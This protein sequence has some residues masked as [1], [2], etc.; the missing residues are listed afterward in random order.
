MDTANWF[1]G[2]MIL[3]K[4]SE[5]NRYKTD[6]LPLA[7][8]K[9]A[10]SSNQN[11][12][13]GESDGFG[14]SF[15]I[16]EN[17]DPIFAARYFADPFW[18]NGFF[19]VNAIVQPLLSP[20]LFGSDAPDMISKLKVLIVEDDFMIA[21]MSEDLLVNGGFDV[22]GIAATVEEAVCLGLRHKPDLALIDFRLADGGFGTE[23]ATRLRAVER[24]GV[25]YATGNSTH[26][27]MQ[28]AEGEAC[29]AKPYRAQ[30]LVRGMKIVAEFVA[31]G[32]SASLFPR[33]FHLLRHP[34]SQP[35]EYPIG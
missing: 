28:D 14:D 30:D 9:N 10:L 26:I 6:A 31:T 7:H 13:A 4:A 8:D 25:L 32:A 2:R 17:W 3:T 29:L 19:P 24:I 20:P 34:Y 22:C 35:A 33:G 5:A 1:R 21:D 16:D 27:G 11:E 12:R 23:V 18:A 15:Q